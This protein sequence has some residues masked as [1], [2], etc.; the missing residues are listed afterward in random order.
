MNTP[1]VV[2]KP[3]KKI[4]P[5][6]YTVTLWSG[7]GIILIASILIEISPWMEDFLVVM[8]LVGI[9][10][11]IY[12]AI[13]FLISL[14]RCWS[15]LQGST[16]RTTPG[17]AVGFLFIPIFGFYWMFVAIRGLSKDANAFLESKNANKTT[18][19]SVGLS[20]ATCIVY[21]TSII[22]YIGILV[23]VGIL[24]PILSTILIY[25]WARF[26]NFSVTNLGAKYDAMRL[27]L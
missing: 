20:T 18:K 19:I 22:P 1:K 24:A 11:I 4:N 13:Y 26:F 27:H 15:I 14:Y 21:I 3:S 7:M 25:Q 2:H 6:L 10:A 23:V 5:H 8:T 16:V 17:K 12:A 9:A